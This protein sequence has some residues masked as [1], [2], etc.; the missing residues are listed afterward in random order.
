MSEPP[1]TVQPEKTSVFLFPS[2]CSPT[3]ITWG[4]GGPGVRVWEPF[5]TSWSRWLA[6]WPEWWTSSCR[7]WAAVLT[8]IHVFVWRNPVGCNL[9]QGIFKLECKVYKVLTCPS[10]TMLVSMVDAAESLCP[11]VMKKSSLRQ[12]LL[13][14]GAGR[15]TVPRSFIT[16]TL[17]EQSGVDIINKIRFDLLCVC[18]CVP[19]VS[20]A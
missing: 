17:L 18:V 9:K 12:E 11:H 1:K 8:F 3:C 15:M 6:R 14:A 4:V 7:C 13:K 20:L 16:A 19:W 2:S 10:Q 5:R